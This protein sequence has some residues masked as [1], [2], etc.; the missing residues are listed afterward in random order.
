MDKAGPDGAIFLIS[1]AV[2]ILRRRKVVRC[3]QFYWT[4]RY[5]SKTER[6]LQKKKRSVWRSSTLKTVHREYRSSLSVAQLVRFWFKRSQSL[7]AHNRQFLQGNLLLLAVCTH[8]VHL[9]LCSIFCSHSLVQVSTAFR[10]QNTPQARSPRN[11]TAHSVLNQNLACQDQQLQSDL[12]VN[13]LGQPRCPGRTCFVAV[14]EWPSKWLKI[15]IQSCLLF[16]KIVRRWGSHCLRRLALLVLYDFT[17]I[18]TALVQ[19]RSA[20]KWSG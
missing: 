1:F 12:W 13:C 19:V 17:C 18:Q 5:F 9:Y 3:V 7:T 20:K 4:R 6:R 8:E 11:A 14:K 16:V 2:V 10:A 15:L